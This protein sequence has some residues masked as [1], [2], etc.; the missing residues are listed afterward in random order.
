MTT[1]LSGLKW[2]LATLCLPLLLFGALLLG[3]AT[4]DQSNLFSLFTGIFAYV[5]LLVALMMS[6]LS[7]RK[8]GAGWQRQ[9]ALA[10]GSLPLSLNHA[11]FTPA[12]GWIELTGQASLV[13]LVVI[14]AYTFVYCLSYRLPQ[15]PQLPGGV[16]AVLRHLNALA[17]IL[18]FL[19]VQLID[20]IRQNLP[21]M[22][23]FYL[24]TIP[25]LWIYL[26]AI[27]SAPFFVTT[28]NQ[29]EDPAQEPRRL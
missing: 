19:H 20:S 6:C 4:T 16:K 7:A 23:A 29:E 9:V 26:R 3:R 1:Y 18:V 22:T 8:L 11:Q 25:A 2:L 24:M 10:F 14:A 5:W 12:T 28:G 27:A 21:F 15:L 17:V 13:S